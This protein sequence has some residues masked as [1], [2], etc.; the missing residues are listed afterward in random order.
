MKFLPDA[1]YGCFGVAVGDTLKAVGAR[2]KALFSEAAR[3]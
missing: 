3:A 1:V 2:C